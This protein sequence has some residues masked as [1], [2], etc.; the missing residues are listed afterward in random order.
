MGSSFA[1]AWRRT[2]SAESAARSR[3]VQEI[4]RRS[5]DRGDRLTV[6]AI[7]AILRD[8]CGMIGAVEMMVE[9]SSESER[10]DVF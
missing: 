3:A 9:W 7:C 6:D 8:R 5:D 10:P 4:A 1:F 2:L